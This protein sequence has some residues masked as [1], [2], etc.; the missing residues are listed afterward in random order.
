MAFRFRKLILFSFFSSTYLF[1]CC[2]NSYIHNETN[3]IKTFIKNEN[4][5]IAT[6]YL[7]AYDANMSSIISNELII[8]KVV[9]KIKSVEY[10][11]LMQDGI[12]LKLKK[13]NDLLKKRNDLITY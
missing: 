8:N 13:Q 12:L 10:N 11:K 5:D 1:G 6:Q 7:N 3:K 2:C 4:L 9:N